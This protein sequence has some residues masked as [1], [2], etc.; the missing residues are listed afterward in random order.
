M[1]SLHVHPVEKR[2]ILNLEVRALLVLYISVC[3]CLQG[4]LVIWDLQ[5]PCPTDQHPFQDKT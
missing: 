2:L 4:T 1:G 5:I 3:Y